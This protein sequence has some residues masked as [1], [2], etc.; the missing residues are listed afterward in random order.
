M[1]IGDTGLTLEELFKTHAMCMHACSLYNL[2]THITSADT[3]V[4][5]PVMNADCWRKSR[6]LSLTRDAIHHSST[7]MVRI[8]PRTSFGRLLK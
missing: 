6:L 1:Q 7:I 3:L 8:S 5:V 4:S 2:M